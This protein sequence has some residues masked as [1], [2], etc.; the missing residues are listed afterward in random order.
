[1]EEESGVVPDAMVLLADHEAAVRLLREDAKRCSDEWDDEGTSE[2]LVSIM[3]QHEK[4]AW[5]LRAYLGNEPNY[6]E[7]Q[8]RKSNDQ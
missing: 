5:V 4:M 7:S 8:N 6:G 2:L 3:R 1:L